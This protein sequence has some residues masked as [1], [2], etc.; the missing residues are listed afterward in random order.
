[1]GPGR[2][3]DPADMPEG[4]APQGFEAFGRGGSIGIVLVH[5]IFGYTPIV[6]RFADALVRAGYPTA[7]VDLYG[8][9]IAQGL[10]G[11]LAMR[12]ALTE[13]HVLAVLERTRLEIVSRLD[14]PARVGTI[15]FSMGGGYALLGACKLPFDFCIDYYGKMAETSQVA[16]LRGP[17]LVLLGSDDDTVTGWALADLLPALNRAKRRVEVHVYP[18]A[19]HAFQRPGWDG[20]EDRAANDAW[21]RTLEFLARIGT[22]TGYLSPP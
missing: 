9:R 22:E 7:A 12:G 2:R 5:E 17:V 21:L 11:A 19:R 3:S 14:P 15:G 20:H 18:G 13:T 6:R 10:E 1:M 8:G 16:G 4:S